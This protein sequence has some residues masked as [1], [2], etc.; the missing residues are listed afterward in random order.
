MSSE[1]AV[2]PRQAP[3]TLREAP[4]PP[5]VVVVDPDYTGLAAA[6]FDE[7]ACKV[8]TRPVTED[9]IEI[10]AHD[11][12]IYLPGVRFRQRLNEAFRPGAWA[13]RPIDLKLQ[14][15]TV[16]YRGQLWILGRFVSESIGEAKYVASNP[17]TS[18][19]SA[20]ES[21][22]TDC[23]TRCCKDLGIGSELWEPGFSR[24][25]VSQ[26]AVKQGGKWMRKDAS[27]TPPRDDAPQEQ[28]WSSPSQGSE[29]IPTIS[30]AQRKRLF[31]IAREGGHS[32]EAIK[33]WLPNAFGYLSTSDI[34]TSD[35][36]A[37]CTRLADPTALD[38]PEPG[39]EG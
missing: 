22:K 38:L 29:G 13:L 37:I 11:G 34:L 7:A 9:E 30:A 28:E 20:I 4:P 33:G 2:V 27:F 16:C 19:A 17:Q 32:H 24:R 31:A 3:L 14:G 15:A 1:T 21:A 35:Y 23:L 36:D 25:W 12:L 5:A 8:L 10:R 39:A 18:Y 26:H 6:P